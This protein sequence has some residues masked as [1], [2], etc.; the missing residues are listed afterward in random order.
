MMKAQH[1][2]SLRLAVIVA[3]WGCGS[4]AEPNVTVASHPS[5][6]TTIVISAP[7]PGQLIQPPNFNIMVGD[8]LRV[9]AINALWAGAESALPQNH[10]TFRTSEPGAASVSEQGMMTALLPGDWWLV[11]LHTAGAAESVLVHARNRAGTFHITPIY[12]AD[13]SAAWR[14]Q[15]DSAA[16]IWEGVIDGA[17]P[18]VEMTGLRSACGVAPGEELIP[19]MTGPERRV[20]IYIHTTTHMQGTGVYPEAV[21]GPCIQRSLPAPTTLLGN[22][23]INSRAPYDSVLPVRRRYGTLHEMGHAL[24]L[25]GAVQGIPPVW[26]DYPTHRYSGPMALEAWRRNTGSMPRFITETSGHWEAKP[27]GDIMDNVGAT[28]TVSRLTLGGLFDL[29]YPATWK[30]VSW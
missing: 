13:V 17:L 21:G 1:I 10:V 15:F 4:T 29:G 19:T 25:V 30:V 23:S 8:S 14:A 2:R 12:S 9:D 20:R 28:N 3:L 27:L 24:G 6:D 11:A 22:I 26:Y 7:V 16:R 5:G 18:E